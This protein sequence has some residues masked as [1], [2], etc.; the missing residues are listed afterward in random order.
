MNGLKT[1]TEMNGGVDALSPELSTKL[2]RADL[3]GASALLVAPHLSF[4]K[5]FENASDILPLEARSAI[6]KTTRVLLLP[7]GVSTQTIDNITS[8][9][10]FARA[11]TLGQ[12]CRPPRSIVFDPYAVTEEW[13]WCQYQL[14][15]SPNVLHSSILATRCSCHDSSHCM[16]LRAPDRGLSW[17]SSIELV[18]RVCAI[19]YTKEMVFCRDWPRNLSGYSVPLNFILRHVEAICRDRGRKIAATRHID[20]DDSRIDPP[21][22]SP[23]TEYDTLMKPVLIW[24][25]LFANAVSLIANR[26]E[27]HLGSDRYDCSIYRVCIV[28]VVG[29]AAEDID[30]LSEDDLMLCHLLDL[31]HITGQEWDD[32]FGLKDLLGGTSN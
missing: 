4:R 17:N 7:C 13:Q 2:R 22:K 6:T 23:N 12:Y 14:I 1:M 20:E 3:K 5:A 15:C 24:I 31:R 19:L 8:L 30:A 21:S 26:N 10:I 25:C 32:R 29:L 16:S 11:L 27:D 28:D 18:L 9:S